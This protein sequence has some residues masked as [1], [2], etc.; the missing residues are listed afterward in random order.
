[1]NIAHLSRLNGIISDGMGQNC[2][3][4]SHRW[5]IFRPCEKMEIRILHI[6]TFDQSWRLPYCW[7]LTFWSFGTISKE[8]LRSVSQFEDSMLYITNRHCAIFI[9]PDMQI[10]TIKFGQLPYCH[11][12]IIVVSY[13]SINKNPRIRPYLFTLSVTKKLIHFGSKRR[14]PR[15]TNPS[16]L[17]SRKQKKFGKAASLVNEEVVL[18]K[19]ETE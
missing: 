2:L 14:M 19:Q 13:A 3:H 18:R 17:S 1:M 6:D 7:T 5:V 9:K 10:H 11:E 4:P 16:C 12:R 8:L 15:A